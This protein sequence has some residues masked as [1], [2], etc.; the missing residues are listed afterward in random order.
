MLEGLT[1]INKAIDWR[2]SGMASQS[3]GRVHPLRR[4]KSGMKVPSINLDAELALTEMALKDRCAS[5]SSHR[6]AFTPE[7]PAG[8]GSGGNRSAGI[9]SGGGL[10]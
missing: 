10:R 2:I 4:S 7:A 6:L 5:S 1:S 3:R 8:A 9:V